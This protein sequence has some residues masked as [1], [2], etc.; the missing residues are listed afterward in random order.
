MEH[1]SEAKVASRDA[2]S[3]I[4][5]GVCNARYKEACFVD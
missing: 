4:V 5:M 3:A 1:L 2:I